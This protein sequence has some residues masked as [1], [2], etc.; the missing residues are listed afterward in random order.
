M[1]EILGALDWHN[2]DSPLLVHGH[3]F[4]YFAQVWLANS[5]ATEDRGKGDLEYWEYVRPSTTL[6]QIGWLAKADVERLLQKL[7]R[8][9][10]KLTDLSL[11][12]ASEASAD[13]SSVQE[14]YQTAVRM[15]RYASEARSGL[16]VLTSG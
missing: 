2:S 11:Q 3:S 4:G 10:S 12:Y 16:C 1:D 5:L 7:I 9:Q 6:A 8:D 15:L 13:E 14:T